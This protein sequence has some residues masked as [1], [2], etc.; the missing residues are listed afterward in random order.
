MQH[1]STPRLAVVGSGRLGTALHR[2]LAAAGLDAGREPLGR[3]ANARG[4]DV[5]LLCVPDREIAA[6]AGAVT[7]GPLVAHTSGAGSLDLVAAHDRR[8][9]LHPLLS[10]PA[11]ATDLAGAWAAI[12][13]RDPRDE[14]LLQD[15]ARRLGMTPFAVSEADRA[16]YHA[17]ASLASNALVALQAAAARVATSAGV[18]AA[19]FAPLAQASLSQFHELGEA[20]LTGP[21]ARGD[22][23]TVDAQRNALAERTPEL[24]PLFD[25]AT[26]ACAQ[27]A[28]RTRPAPTT[29]AVT[30]PSSVEPS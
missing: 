17:A 15:L 23:G 4:A 2:A 28:G 13:A 8:G 1:T 14:A 9:V 29:P 11:G 24:I 7:P 19:A 20:A 16:A 21:A 12:R 27:M 5:V 3:G 10:V 22:W 26:D 18:P 30:S 25:A 6:A